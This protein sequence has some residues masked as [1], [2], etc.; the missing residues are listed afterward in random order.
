MKYSTLLAQVIKTTKRILISCLIFPLVSC[1]PTDKSYIIHGNACKLWLLF[2]KLNSKS[3]N[4]PFVICFDRD[5]YQCYVLQSNG[6]LRKR[7]TSDVHD[8]DLS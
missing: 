8:S 7:K 6:S 1:Q 5:Y 2:D 4:T 3:G